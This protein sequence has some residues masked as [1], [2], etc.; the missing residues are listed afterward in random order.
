MKHVTLRNAWDTAC[1][2][3]AI[4]AKSNNTKTNFPVVKPL[5]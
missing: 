1:G 5:S 3:A 2:F 4:V